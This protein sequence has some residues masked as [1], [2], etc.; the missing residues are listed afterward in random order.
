MAGREDPGTDTITIG[1]EDRIGVITF[2]RPDRRN[3]L[4][5]D[6]YEPMIA[7]VERFAGDQAVGALVVTGSGS[8]FCAGGDVRGGRNSTG[9]RPSAPPTPEEAA[10]GLMQIARLARVLHE[11]TS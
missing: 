8:A 9:E 2:D 10:A 1:V 5:P 6:M 4:H 7:A 3:A 11:A